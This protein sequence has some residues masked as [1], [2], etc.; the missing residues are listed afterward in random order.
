M[1]SQVEQ[2]DIYHQTKR[3]TVVLI[4]HTWLPI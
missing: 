4:S 2:S 3:A 1:V